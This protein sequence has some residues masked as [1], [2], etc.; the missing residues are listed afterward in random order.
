MRRRVA[1][2]A[3]GFRPLGVAMAIAMMKTSLYDA[4]LGLIA[5]GCTVKEFEGND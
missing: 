1:G 2:R 3:G 5:R 4:G